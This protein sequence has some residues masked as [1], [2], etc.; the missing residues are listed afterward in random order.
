MYYVH[1][2]T[3]LSRDGHFIM[4]W[5]GIVVD[6][7][8]RG[9]IAISSQPLHIWYSGVNELLISFSNYT[10]DSCVYN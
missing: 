7:E 10:V 5:N 2:Y 6:G 9:G 1:T 8:R 3:R 4:E